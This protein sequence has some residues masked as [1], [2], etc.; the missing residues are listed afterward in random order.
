MTGGKPRGR[1]NKI[2][3]ESP[4]LTFPRSVHEVFKKN[5]HITHISTSKKLQTNNIKCSRNV[6]ENVHMTDSKNIDP[7]RI[8]NL[9]LE[10]HSIRQIASIT[11]LSVGKV[12]NI[13]SK[14]ES[15]IASQSSRELQRELQALH[16]SSNQLDNDVENTTR[17]ARKTVDAV[18]NRIDSLLPNVNDVNALAKLLQCL[19]TTI[20]K[21]SAL[22]QEEQNTEQQNTFINDFNKRHP[23]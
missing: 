16:I 22:A 19:A 17:K 3:G 9:H 6:H 11:G 23:S 13:L 2:P 8:I 12:H 14:K 20:E 7:S 4:R 1:I 15:A 21:L 18:L 5:V 10:G